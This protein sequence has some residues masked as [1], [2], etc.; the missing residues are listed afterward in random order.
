MEQL[1]KLKN[2]DWP[3]LIIAKHNWIEKKLVCHPTNKKQKITA[4]F[5]SIPYA[6]IQQ[7]IISFSERIADSIENY[8]F[9]EKQL[10]EM[11]EQDIKPFRKA[12]EFFGDTNPIVDGK[13]GELILYCLCEHVLKTPMV[14]HKIASLTNVNDQVKGGDGVF[15]GSYN[16]NLSILIGESKIYTTFS[17]ALDSAFDSLNRFNEAYSGSALSHEMFFVRSNIS[18]NFDIDTLDLLYQAFTP[19]SDIYNECIKTHP[20][21]IIFEDED[22]LK[23]EVNSMSKEEAEEKFNT[24]IEKKREVICDVINEK[25][26]K[27]PNMASYMLDFFLIPMKNVEHFKNTLFRKIHGIDFKKNN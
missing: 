7:E 10:Q 13:Y 15:I 4:R 17:K 9:S 20:V 1:D 16:E 12:A 26:K 24:W 3:S 18:D 25:Y 14:T 6:G 5:Y 21:L 11:R 27:Y 2:I 22:L 8:V 19:G 23:I